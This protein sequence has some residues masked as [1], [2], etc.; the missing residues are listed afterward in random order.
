[1]LDNLNLGEKAEKL[2]GGLQID[3]ELTRLSMLGML[4]KLTELD[5]IKKESEAT[6][7]FDKAAEHV[8]QANNSLAYAL[9]YIH[10]TD[11]TCQLTNNPSDDITDALKDWCDSLTDFPDGWTNE[12]K[13]EAFMTA[14]L[15]GMGN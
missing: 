6:E 10:D 3:L 8:L 14:L 1:M 15:K 11:I 7:Y 13:Q 4:D 2:I 12:E 5:V 9:R